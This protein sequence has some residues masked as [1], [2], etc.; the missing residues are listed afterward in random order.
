MNVV[1]SRRALGSTQPPIQWVPGALFP[2]VK[3]QRREASHSPLPS[4]EVKK[5]WIYVSIPPYAFTA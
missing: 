4:A 1:A 5:T 2:G 3:R